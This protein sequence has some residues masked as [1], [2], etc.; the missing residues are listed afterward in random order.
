M[1]VNDFAAAACGLPPLG[2]STYTPLGFR[3]ESPTQTY[4]AEVRRLCPSASDLEE[5]CTALHASMVDA[6]VPELEWMP[7]NFEDLS[8][9]IFRANICAGENA[10]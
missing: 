4:I 1:N 8:D 5:L 7:V 10:E 3:Y 9:A 6:D 2:E